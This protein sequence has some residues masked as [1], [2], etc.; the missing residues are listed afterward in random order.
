[1][2]RNGSRPQVLTSLEAETRKPHPNYKAQVC[3]SLSL[4]PSFPPVASL[5]PVADESE[6]ERREGGREGGREGEKPHPN[7]KAQVCLQRECA[8]KRE[9]S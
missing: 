7:Y 9:R 4:S 3:L 8:R 5:E 2:L 6:G 1:M